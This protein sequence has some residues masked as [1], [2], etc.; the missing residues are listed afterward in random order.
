MTIEQMFRIEE[1]KEGKEY[2]MLTEEDC[3]EREDTMY[4]EYLKTDRKKMKGWKVGEFLEKITFYVLITFVI[5][6]FVLLTLAACSHNK[7]A[8]DYIP[9]SEKTIV[10]I[11]VFSVM[12]PIIVYFVFLIVQCL[13]YELKYKYYDEEKI[14]NALSPADSP[15][16]YRMHFPLPSSEASVFTV[17]GILIDN[18]IRIPSPDEKITEKLEETEWNEYGII[19][20]D[21]TGFTIF[22]IKEN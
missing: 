14:L 20:K 2:R 15:A 9:T 21:K 4:L 12:S 11:W 13:A 18:G 17:A 8:A 10:I 16:I 6:C 3:I 19:R 1:K 5:G 22:C 7:M